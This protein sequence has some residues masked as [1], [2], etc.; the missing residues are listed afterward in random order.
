[1]SALVANYDDEEDGEEGEDVEETSL[2]MRLA[3]SIK[4]KRKREGG[5]SKTVNIGTRT[6]YVKHY[7]VFGGKREL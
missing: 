6:T 4:P 5:D 3:M 2:A 7:S 1:M